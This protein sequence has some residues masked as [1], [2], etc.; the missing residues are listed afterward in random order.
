MNIIWSPA[1]SLDGYIA[2]LDGSSNWVSD[3]HGEL[4]EEPIRESGCVI[5][6]RTTHEQY[7]G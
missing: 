6:G 3:G 2:K 1:V 7:E 5:F 4:F